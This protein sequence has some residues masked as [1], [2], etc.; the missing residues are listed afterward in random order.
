VIDV[1]IYL[2]VALGV[3]LLPQLYYSV[4]LWLFF[5]V[6]VGWLAYLVV[7][8]LVV[9]DRRVAYPLALV[10]SILTLVASLPRPEHYAFVEAGISLASIT[11]LVGS[12][13]QLALVIL[14]PIYLLRGKAQLS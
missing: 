11:F 3:V 9:A 8:G 10:L 13:L 14:I 1:L 12:G 5:S 2:S 7:A 4:P 6:L